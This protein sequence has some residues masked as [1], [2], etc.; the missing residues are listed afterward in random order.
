M[1]YQS[2]CLYAFIAATSQ[3]LLNLAK[4]NDLLDIAAHYEL[5]SVKRSM[6]KYEI[7][8]ILIQFFVD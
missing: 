4:K 6:L 5:I 8:N 3:E 1:I 7:K 2:K